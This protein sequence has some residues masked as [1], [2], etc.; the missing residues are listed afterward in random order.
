MVDYNT[1]SFKF[2]G[3]V[4]YRITEKAELIGQLNYGYGTTVYTGTGRYSLREFNLTQAKLEL[5][6]SQLCIAGLHDAGTLG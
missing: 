6:G 2:N 4:H 3:A 1:K 5:K